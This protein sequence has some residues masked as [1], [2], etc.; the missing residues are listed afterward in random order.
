MNRKWLAAVA[1]TAIAVGLGVAALH[2]QRTIVTKRGRT[3]IV[4]R[5]SDRAWLASTCST[6]STSSRS[7]KPS[8]TGSGVWAA[9]VLAFVPV[10]VA[11][12]RRG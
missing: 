3:N 9:L 5:S 6:T 8:S 7:T 4:A 1:G 11:R 12:Y 10:A 2:A